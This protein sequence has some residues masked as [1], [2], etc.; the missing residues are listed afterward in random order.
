MVIDFSG[1][2]IKGFLCRVN[3][4]IDN[5]IYKLRAALLNLILV[6]A[7]LMSLYFL[8]FNIWN[9]CEGSGCI[10]EII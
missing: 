10:E 3:C 8:I 7:L 9:E 2:L 4:A 6:S 5:P 1:M